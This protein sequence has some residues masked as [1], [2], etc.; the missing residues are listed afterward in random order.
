MVG[1]YTFDLFKRLIVIN[2]RQD[3][4]DLGWKKKLLGK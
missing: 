1:F 2:E 3:T 4:G